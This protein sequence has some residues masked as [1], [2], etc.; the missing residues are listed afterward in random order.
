M[1][2]AQELFDIVVAHLRKQG[3]KAMNPNGN[4]LYRTKDGLSCA[5]GCLI[6]DN[7]YYSDLEYDNLPSIIQNRKLSTMLL[8]EFNEH[9]KLL[10]RLQEVHDLN[11][12]YEWE[13]KLQKVANEFKLNYSAP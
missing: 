2:T 5:V 10:V 7:E 11:E 1:R 6:P 9:S 3:A 8:E 12:V 13:E 4:C